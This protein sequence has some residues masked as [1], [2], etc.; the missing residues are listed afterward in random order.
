MQILARSR[1]SMPTRAP[2]AVM[3]RASLASILSCCTS[4][5]EHGVARDHSAHALR[6]VF[7]EL[8]L[9]ASPRLCGRLPGSPA[10]ANVPEGCPCTPPTFIRPGKPRPPQPLHPSVHMP[11]PLRPAPPLFPAPLP[12]HRLRRRAQP[13]PSRGRRALLA[14]RL[15]SCA[16]HLI[17]QCV[18][19]PISG[20]LPLIVLRVVVFGE[21]LLFEP[22]LPLLPCIIILARPLVRRGCRGTAGG[23][24][25]SN[26]GRRALLPHRLRSRAYHLIIQPAPATPPTPHAPSPLSCPSVMRSSAGR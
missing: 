8:G 3:T 24:R 19:F 20:R 25:R 11:H 12:R 10:L 4:S 17:C 16:R 2:P 5:P 15:R 14:R 6:H 18:R 9:L 1:R 13:R 7:P 26:Y 21:Q 22:R 23:A